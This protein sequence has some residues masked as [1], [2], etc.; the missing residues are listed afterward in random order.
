MRAQLWLWGSDTLGKDFSNVHATRDLSLRYIFVWMVENK[1]SIQLTW[2]TSHIYN[3]Y[4]S[5][6]GWD[7]LGNGFSNFNTTRDLSTKVV[8]KFENKTSTQ[9]TWKTSHVL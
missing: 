6:K 7:A 3:L 8:W 4:S 2:K 9:L 1:T 5:L